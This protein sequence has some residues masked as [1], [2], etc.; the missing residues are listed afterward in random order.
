M[1]I[2]IVYGTTDGMTGRIAQRMSDIARGAGHVADV[3]RTRRGL[4]PI[5]VASYD[6]VVVG[7]SL[8]A[9]GYQRSVAR[10]VKQHR[11]DLRRVPTTAFFAVCL[12]IASKFPKEREEAKRIA[13]EFP[14]KLGWIPDK[15]EVIAGALMFSK[16][17]FL[18]KIAMKKIAEHEIGEVDPAQDHVYTDWTLVDRFVLEL[19]ARGAQP[20]AAAQAHP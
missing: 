7:A 10:F 1:K 5:P 17:G 18:R 15:I 4:D 8:H 12:A 13:S 19:I 14:A 2:L 9:G 3:I 11:E 20:A 6:A 16:Y